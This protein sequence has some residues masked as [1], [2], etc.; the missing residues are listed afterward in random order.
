MAQLC[1]VDVK[2]VG[3]PSA[4]RAWIEIHNTGRWTSNHQ[5]ALRK[6]GVDRNVFEVDDKFNVAVALRKEGVDRNYWPTLA[7]IGEQAVALRKEGVDRNNGV[8]AYC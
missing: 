2:I 3:S 6:E 4:R 8:E 5:V 7:N 1:C